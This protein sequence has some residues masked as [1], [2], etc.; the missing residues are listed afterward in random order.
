[1][2]DSPELLKPNV[3]VTD[4]ELQIE[5]GNSKIENE[6][7]KVDYAKLLESSTHVIDK[8]RQEVQE[9]RS[10][11]ETEHA[12]QEEIEA[13]LSPAKARFCSGRHS[14]QKVNTRRGHNS[15]PAPSQT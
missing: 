2:S 7:L 13:E 8:L 12:D 11:F 14:S 15:Q 4:S 6:T 5:L 1:L 10:Q 3:E 9:L